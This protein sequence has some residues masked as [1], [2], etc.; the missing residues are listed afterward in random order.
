M[1]QVK[2]YLSAVHMT[3]VSC[4]QLESCVGEDHHTVCVCLRDVGQ[5]LASM[6]AEQLEKTQLV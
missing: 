3:T 1:G 2:L 5:P 4:R 6:G